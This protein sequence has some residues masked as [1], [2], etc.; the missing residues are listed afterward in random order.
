MG[1][2]KNGKDKVVITLEIDKIL[3]EPARMM[4][5]GELKVSRNITVRHVLG[6]VLWSIL[7]KKIPQIDTKGFQSIDLQF[8]KE[9]GAIVATIDKC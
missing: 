7:L 9:V 3:A 2:I 5:D 8:D 6:W 4:M 1:S